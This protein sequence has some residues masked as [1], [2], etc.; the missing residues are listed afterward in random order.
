LSTDLGT[1]EQSILTALGTTKTELETTLGGQ[2]SDVETTLGGQISDVETTLGEQISGLETTFSTDINAIADL[3]G[4]PAREVTESDVDFVID[5][6]AQQNV[7]DELVLEYDVTGDGTVDQSDVD[8]L[9]QTLTGEDTTLADTSIF[10]PATGLF[11]QQ[12]QDTQTTQ[13]LITD[14]ATN[15]NTQINTQTQQ[16]NVADLAELLA[17]ARDAGGT[18][19]DVKTPQELANITPYDFQTIFRDQQQAGKFVGPYGDPRTAFGIP[20]NVS[21]P[22]LGRVS[23]FS[24]GGQVEDNNDMLLRILG[25]LE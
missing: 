12:E 23:G 8:L 24:Q 25:E 4:K 2:I 9:Q 19:V 17:G 7:N 11:A 13:D 15:I 6:V 18:R 22:P 20:A 21:R 16:Q 10:T 3:I 5:L 14:L 1:T